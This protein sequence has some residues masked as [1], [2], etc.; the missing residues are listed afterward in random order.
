MFWHGVMNLVVPYRGAIFLDDNV[1]PW[2]VEAAW[3]TCSRQVTQSTGSW[4][5]DS[6]MS[7]VQNLTYYNLID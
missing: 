1:C 3:H 7:S 6:A 2:E 4:D 5:G